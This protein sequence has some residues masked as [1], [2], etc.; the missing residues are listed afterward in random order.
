M[1]TKAERLAKLEEL[2]QLGKD[3]ETNTDYVWRFE[4]EQP[5]PTITVLGAVHGNEFVGV[6]VV[7]KLMIEAIQNGVKYGVLQLGIGHPEAF[8]EGIRGFNKNDLNRCFGQN[9]QGEEETKRAEELKPWLIQTDVLLDV[10]ATIKDSKPFLVKVAHNGQ[11]KECIPELGISTIINETQYL[12]EGDASESDIFVAAH[13]SNGNGGLGLTIEAG[14]INDP[15]TSKVIHGILA[16][17]HKLGI[18]EN[19]PEEAPEKPEQFEEYYEYAK[20]KAKGNF[21]FKKNP[22]TNK[23]WQNFD[24]IPAGTKIAM[25]NNHPI[26]APFDSII[27]FPKSKE[28]IKPGVITCRLARHHSATHSIAA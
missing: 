15:K 6:E 27:L 24:F 8:K 19:Y 17:L 18:F 11:F 7:E 21:E 12:T 25:D 14:P 4:G 3:H 20:I 26:I 13:G 16:A 22:S 28:Y 10:H 23:D 5:G 2:E 9:P 1:E